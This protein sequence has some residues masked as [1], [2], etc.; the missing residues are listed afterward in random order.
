MSNSSQQG[1]FAFQRFLAALS[2]DPEISPKLYQELRDKLVRYFTLRGLLRADEA[3][4]ETIDRVVKKIEDG[5]EIDN[6]T[7]FSYGVARLVIFEFFRAQGKESGALKLFEHHEVPADDEDETLL[8]VFLRECLAELS[9][10]SKS[11]VLEY[12]SFNGK[13]SKDREKVAASHGLTLNHLRVKIYRIKKKLGRCVEGK[14]TG[15]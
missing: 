7:R 12:Y 11:L 8:A 15:K 10:D 5:A 1:D 3:A 6:V 13:H 14:R 4:D 9:E 2:S